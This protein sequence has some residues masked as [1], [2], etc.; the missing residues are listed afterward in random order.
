MAEIKKTNW[1]RPNV[2]GVGGFYDKTK[3][4]PPHN[5]ISKNMKAYASINDV[6]IDLLI[7]NVLEKN[8]AE[9]EILQICNGDQTIEGLYEGDIVHIEREFINHLDQTNGE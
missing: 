2:K 8:V 3:G 9:A 7:I 5:Y 4:I 1:D 6:R